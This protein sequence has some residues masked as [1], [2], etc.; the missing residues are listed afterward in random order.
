MLQQTLQKNLVAIH[1]RLNAACRRAGRPRS[2]VTLVAVTKMVSA[3]VAACLPALG[4]YH[5]GEN[6]P[7]ELCRKPRY[8]P[9]RFTGT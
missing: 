4:V 9:P 1:D 2:E 5:L 3:N 8:C 7:Q 6:R